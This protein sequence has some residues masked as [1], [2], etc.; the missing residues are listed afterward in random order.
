MEQKE[1]HV[2]DQN[3]TS[4][5]WF[6][7]RGK[8][9]QEM[10]AKVLDFILDRGINGFGPVKSATEIAEE[11]LKN[12]AG[13]REK[14]IARL[15]A[16]H[17]RVV[18]TTGFVTGLGGL[19]TL[20]VSIPADVTLFYTRAAR[21]TAA[22]AHLRGYDVESED[23]RSLVAV[24]LVGSAGAEA[25]SKAGVEIGK[26]AAVAQLRRLPGSVL[27]KINRA[28]GFRLITKFGT[29]GSVNL[30]KWVPGVGGMVGGTV[31]VAGIY[32]IAKYAKLNFP[33]ADDTN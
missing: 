25:L 13:D 26:R 9:L 33:A 6:S 5:G 20:P 3:D 1:S 22:I 7:A 11:T 21:M 24:S 17:A 16:A 14:A 31:N 27:T 30:V 8:D 19:P 28:V 2:S 29:K 15:I 23:V 4:N 32:G 18:G 12:T 10:G